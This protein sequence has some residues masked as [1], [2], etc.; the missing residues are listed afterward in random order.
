MEKPAIEKIAFTMALNPGRR[1][2]YERRHDEIWP[3]LVTELKRA[4]ISDYSIF[5]DSD[6]NT[7]FAVLKRSPDHSMDQLPIKPIMQKWWD[8]M[9]DIMETEA[10]NKPATKAL[11][12]VFHL[13]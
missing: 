2:D 7:L 9:A 1:E 3:D 10:D 8:H 13:D 11:E 4:G 6:T 5:L 12:M